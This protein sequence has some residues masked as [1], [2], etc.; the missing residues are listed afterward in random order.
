M[1][2]GLQPPTRPDCNMYEIRT[3]C[4]K[5]PSHMC[6]VPI[7]QL[8]NVERPSSAPKY[9]LLRLL[10]VH[11]GPGWDNGTNPHQSHVFQLSQCGHIILN[12]YPIAYQILGSRNWYTLR[13]GISFNAETLSELVDVLSRISIT[14]C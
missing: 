9:K 10:A 4:L 2:P 1:Q 13:R 7:G 6:K 12:E 8:R 3:L 5:A 11:A 14:S